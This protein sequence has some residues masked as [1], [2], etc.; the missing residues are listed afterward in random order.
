MKKIIA[1]TLLVATGLVFVISCKKETK[2]DN[3]DK[4]GLFTNYADNLII[5]AYTNYG[6]SLT[7]LEAAV[8]AFNAAPD[9]ALFVT[10]Q[11]ALLDAWEKWQYCEIYEKTDPADVAQLGY[12]TNFYPTDTT[13]LKTNVHANNITPV[14]LKNASFNVKGLPAL[15]YLFF[16][17]VNTRAQLMEKFMISNPDAANYR[18]YAASLVS[19]IKRLQSTVL[20]TWSTHRDVFINAVGTDAASSFSAMV[21]AISYRADNF[22]TFQ[23]GIP[24]GYVGN[25]PTANFFPGKVQAYFSNHSIAYMLLTLNDLENVMKGGSGTGMYDYLKNLNVTSSIGGDLADDIMAQILVCKQKVNDCGSDFAA[26]VV[27]DKPKAEALFL[28]IKKLTVLLKV[29][30][31]SAVGVSISYTDNDGD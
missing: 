12:N 2:T 1:L 19:E 26:T 3:F 25:V 29:D 11:N 17:R 27:N 4:T 14:F 21:N 24:A 13:A 28:E 18:Q 16:S 30:V 9:T 6:T 20:S 15:E 5:P 23:V 22:K 10:V 7:T 31:P 8:T